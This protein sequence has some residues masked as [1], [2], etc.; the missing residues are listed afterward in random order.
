MIK[1]TE[2]DL[3]NLVKETILFEN[4]KIAKQFLQSNKITQEEFNDI[5]KIDPTPTKKYMGWMSK[6]M[7]TEKPTFDELRNAVTEFDNIV[8]GPAKLKELIDYKKTKG[9]ISKQEEDEILS[10]IDIYKIKTFKELKELVDELMNIPSIKSKE[11]EKKFEV[12]YNNDQIYMVEPSTWEATAKLCQS[13]FAIDDTDRY[14]TPIKKS[15]WCT[16]ANEMSNWINYVYSK[17]WT[18]YYALAHGDKIREELINTFGKE[19]G[20]NFTKMA[21]CV[22]P[23]KNEQGEDATPPFRKE[24]Y[25]V[26][27]ATDTEIIGKYGFNDFA[28]YMD[29][30][31]KYEN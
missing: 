12:H 26:Y 4:K 2:S 7:S 6:V 23:F 20:K 8:K 15:P 10:K 16:G 13:K 9:S 27:D 18:F 11:K 14:G 28:T 1:I 29:I 21:I 19:K 31:D 30:L 17:Q 25:E 24:Y 5:E 3:F 22:R